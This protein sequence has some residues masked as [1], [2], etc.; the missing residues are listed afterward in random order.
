MW[1]QIGAAGT[2]YART[3]KPKA[4]QSTTLP[5]PG[6]I[7]DSFLA[8][9]DY[10]E[11]PIK[12]SSVLFYLAAIITHDLFRTNRTDFSVSDYHHIRI[13]LLSTEA[14]KKDQDQMRTFKGGRIKPYC[15][16]EKRLLGFPPRAGVLLTMFGPFHNHVVE[17]LA[18]INESGRSSTIRRPLVKRLAMRLKRNTTMPF[19][20]RGSSQV[21]CSICDD[22]DFPI[23]CLCLYAL[24]LGIYSCTLPHM[25]Q[26]SLIPPDTRALR[27]YR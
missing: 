9:K 7:Y 25:V 23:I 21:H 8:R 19:S 2:P 26:H 16:S 22:C 24:L 13:W 20:R 4:I 11:H 5:D 12:I 18:F 3:V 1:P 10:K 14:T 27:N 15:F 6:V 17:K